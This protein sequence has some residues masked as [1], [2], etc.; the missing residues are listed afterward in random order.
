MSEAVSTRSVQGIRERARTDA[1]R[2]LREHWTPGV[3]PIQPVNIARALGLQVFSA[4]LGDDT[5]GMLVGTS[6]GVDMYLDRDQ[7]PSRFRFS[8]AHEIG[9]F[10]DRGE[11]LT[12]D[13]AF[14]D[15]RSELDRGQSDEIYANEFAASLLMPEVDFRRAIASG[16]D[17]FDL[18]AR[19]QVSLDAVRWR[20][21]HLGLQR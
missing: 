17:D 15:K 12:P 10:I 19:F 14:V 18:A 21:H 6:T 13:V 9:H 5:W 4:E 7:P 1:E 3:V 8:C 16:E 2:I 20:V 11:D